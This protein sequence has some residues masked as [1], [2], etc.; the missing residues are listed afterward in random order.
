MAE[1]QPSN[2]LPSSPQSD[3]LS[4]IHIKRQLDYIIGGLQNPGLYE[5]ADDGSTTWRTGSR[6]LTVRPCFLTEE[7]LL[8]AFCC[9]LPR[10]SPA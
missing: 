10:L 4:W 9:T 1:F 8:T 7:T 6:C 5:S 3:S 2:T